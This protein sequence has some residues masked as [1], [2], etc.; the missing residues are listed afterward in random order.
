MLAMSTHEPN[1]HI[2]REQVLLPAGGPA[3]P[4]VEK[5]AVEDDLKLEQQARAGGSVVSRKTFQLLSIPVIREYFEADV[6]VD[7]L[8]FAWDLERGTY[9]VVCVPAPRVLCVM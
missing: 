6:R 2:L 7:A 4:T 8:P 5:R 1:F 3:A 9:L